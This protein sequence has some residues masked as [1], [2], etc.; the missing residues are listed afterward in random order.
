MLK[1]QKDIFSHFFIPNFVLSQAAQAK[2]H[3]PNT[4]H[5]VG[6]EKS[7]MCLRGGGIKTLYLLQS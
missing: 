3:Q 4:Q 6:P 5:T 2:Q 1:H 7:G